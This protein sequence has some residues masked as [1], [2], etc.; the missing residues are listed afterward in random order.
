M[1]FAAGKSARVFVSQHD[2]SGMLKQ[3]SVSLTKD[4]LDTTCF[5]DSS[6]EFIEGLRNGNASMSGLFDA[7]AAASPNNAGSDVILS[8]L[9]TDTSTEPVSI[10]PAGDTNS[11]GV[12]QFGYTASVW[13]GSYETGA[14]FDGLT[15]VAAALQASGG[16]KRA[17]AAVPY[18]AAAYTATQTF[19]AWDYTT[20][21][22]NGLTA[23]YHMPFYTSGTYTVIIED[24]PDAVTYT[25]RITLTLTGVGSGTSSWAGTAAR[26]V[27]ARISA[28]G[29][30]GFFHVNVSR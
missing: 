7:A 14:T 20:T 13:A 8:A 26:Y 19:G 24:S 25:T 16:F 11:G 10:F 2:L 5:Q 28:V 27:R 22:T 3:V 23:T 4:V 29:A 1:A 9:A 18:P 17:M 21:S 15:T 30:G 6:R 12:V